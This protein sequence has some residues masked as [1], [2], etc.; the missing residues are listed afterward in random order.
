LGNTKVDI[1]ELKEEDIYQEWD[2][3]LR[4]QLDPV[5]HKI[6]SSTKQLIN[7]VADMRK[8]LTYNLFYIMG[9]KYRYL[10]RYDCVTFYQYLE[11][12]KIRDVAQHS[13]WF[14]MDAADKLFRVAKNR[15]YITK[16]P[17]PPP[18]VST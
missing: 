12:L 13:M 7:D 16:R 8:L 10:V 1:G 17:A 5:W 6:G 14:Y 4:G 11:S 18:K 15:V 2:Q 3:I 9:L